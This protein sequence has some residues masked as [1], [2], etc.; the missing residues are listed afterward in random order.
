M[1][2]IGEIGSFLIIETNISLISTGILS[3]DTKATYCPFTK[4]RGFSLTN[5]SALAAV[6]N[7]NI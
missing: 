4:E 7:F 1:L 3:T 2:L 5:F 6:L